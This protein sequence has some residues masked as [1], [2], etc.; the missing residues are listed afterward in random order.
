M[1]K[2]LKKAEGVLASITRAFVSRSPEVYLKLF[3]TLVRPLLE[4]ASPVWNPQQVGMCKRVEAVQRR[5]TRRIPGLRSQAYSERLSSLNLESLELRRRVADLV[6]LHKLVQQHDRHNL[7]TFSSSSRTRGHRY[8]IMSQHVKLNLRKL[9]SGIL[10]PR[11]SS[12]LT[13]SRVSRTP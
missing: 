12:T 11:T 10:F 3:T 13:R 2:I 9:L 4:Y 7:F 5:A 6:L 1:R 8:K